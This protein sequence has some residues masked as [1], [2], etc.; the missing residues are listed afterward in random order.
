M[1]AAL[2]WL[3][4][5]APLAADAV[6]LGQLDDFENGTTQGWS[7]GAMHPAPPSN[8]ATGGPAGVDDNYLRL[9]SLGASGAGSRLTA[10]NSTQ[11]TG[12]FSGA[13]VTGIAMQLRNLG[14]TPLSLRLAFSSATDIAVS[15]L[16]IALPVA[17]GWT[18]VV[19]PI[20]PSAL[21][22]L[23]GSAAGALAATIELRL[24][25]STLP[26]FSGEPIAATLGVDDVVAVPEPSTL[27]LLLLGMLALA[28]LSASAAAPS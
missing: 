27:A 8:V 21:T 26:L 2:A 11:W 4:S 10:F 14:S 16:P 18:P 1:A 23:S 9:T 20:A 6:T 5:L 3:V 22:S 12:S 15:T 19:F 7:S 24:L 17:S 25:H 28:A 13:G